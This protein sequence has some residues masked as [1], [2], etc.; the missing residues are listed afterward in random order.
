[1]LTAVQWC[2]VQAPEVAAGQAYSA[3][4]DLFSLGVIF[5]EMW[6][7][8]ATGHE[9]TQTLQ[10][11]RAGTLPEALTA[12]HPIATKLITALLHEDAAQRPAAF[13]VW[14]LWAPVHV[15]IRETATCQPCT[16]A[17]SA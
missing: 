15:P 11:C 5:C 2:C 12:A 4:V 10:A 13:E 8:F 7:P 1:M 14:L 6:L 17:R 9:R 16:L 3:K